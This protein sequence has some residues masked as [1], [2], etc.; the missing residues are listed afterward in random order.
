[1]VWRLWV[2]CRLRQSSQG[3]YTEPPPSMISRRSHYMPRV[4]VLRGNRRAKGAPQGLS[5]PSTRFHA[6]SLQH[7]HVAAE[8]IAV[9]SES[10]IVKRAGPVAAIKVLVEGMLQIELPGRAPASAGDEI[11]HALLFEAL[12]VV[13]VA[14]ADRFYLGRDP[15]DEM[16]LGFPRAGQA[17]GVRVRRMVPDEQDVAEGGVALAPGQKVPEPLVLLA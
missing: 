3:I 14:A 16:L 1:M 4:P 11:D 15:G 2:A 12:V 6:P 8:R 5:K 9:D 17:P 7:D 10:A 13:H